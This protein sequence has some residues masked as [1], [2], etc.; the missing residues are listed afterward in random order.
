VTGSWRKPNT[1]KL[2]TLYFSPDIVRMFISR[3]MRWAEHVAR[4]GLMINVY[5]ILFGKLEGKILHGR[6][7]R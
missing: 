6:P 7:R 1:E 2:H 5:R 3:M 4:V